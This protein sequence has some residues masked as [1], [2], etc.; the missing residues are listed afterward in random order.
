MPIT[1]KNP[2]VERLAREAARLGQTSMTRAIQDALESRMVQ[3][4]GKRR[5]SSLKETLLEMSA[6][7]ASLPDLD[8]RSAD[9]ILGYD[10]QGLTGDGR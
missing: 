8:T 1:I 2:E 3:L 9:A 6:R 7:C 4:Q 5:A 10:E